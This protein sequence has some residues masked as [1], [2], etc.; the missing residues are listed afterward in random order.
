MKKLFLTRFQPSVAFHVETSQLFCSAKQMS[1]FYMK[2]NIGLKWVNLNIDI[3][4][5]MRHS[6]L[7][8]SLNAKVAIIQK[9][10]SID[11]Q[12]KLTG[13]QT[14]ATLAFSELGTKNAA[15]RLCV[16]TFQRFKMLLFCSY[17]NFALFTTLAK[18]PVSEII[19]L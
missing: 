8:N 10:Q 11:F 19:F 15:L 18:F 17:L 6:I 13:F 3:V 4:R 9:P 12:S 7:F 2:R 1:G 14:I 5:K 16:L